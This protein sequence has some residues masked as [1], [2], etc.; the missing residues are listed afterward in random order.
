VSH[1]DLES[2]AHVVNAEEKE[3]QLQLEQRQET[4]AAAMRLL[5][6]GVSMFEVGV[7]TGLPR[8]VVLKLSE[9]LGIGA[10]L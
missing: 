6:Q 3:T 1:I 7:V 9:R 4:E 2:H 5:T 10:D 8:D